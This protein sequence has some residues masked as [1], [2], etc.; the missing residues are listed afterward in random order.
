MQALTGF[1]VLCEKSVFNDP[2]RRA[3]GFPERPIVVGPACHNAGVVGPLG[4][5][6]AP[7]QPFHT[8]HNALPDLAGNSK[9]PVGTPEVAASQT[10]D[11][12]SGVTQTAREADN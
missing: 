8:F 3:V 10:M 9:R 6:P 4:N 1:M 7:Y 12:L 5:I 11:M 2:T